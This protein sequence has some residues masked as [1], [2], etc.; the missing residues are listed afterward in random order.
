MPGLAF[1]QGLLE[2]IINAY[3]SLHPPTEHPHIIMGIEGDTLIGAVDAWTAVSRE[4]LTEFEDDAG[5][6]SNR[7]MTA[8]L[9]SVKYDTSVCDADVD[10]A[11]APPDAL[12]DM[13]SF[14]LEL[15][16][17]YAGQNV[18][19]TTA[20]SDTIDALEG[21]IVSTVAQSGA[22]Y[23]EEDNP[24][25]W[26]FL[27]GESGVSL[28]TPFQPTEIE[29]TPY[30]PWQTLWY[31]G[32]HSYFLE[33]NVEIRNPHPFRF[34]TPAAEVTWAAVL[35]RFWAEGEIRPGVDVDTFFCTAE[36]IPMRGE[37]A[38]LQ[39]ALRPSNSSITRGD[40]LTI[41]VTISNT[42][43]ASATDP[44]LLFQAHS[45]PLDW[46]QLQNT[47]PDRN[48]TTEAPVTRCQLPAMPP[49]TTQML[50]L[51]YQTTTDGATSSPQLAMQAKIFAATFEPNPVDNQETLRIDVLPAPGL[52]LYLPLVRWPD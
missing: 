4:L 7:L 27:G 33:E 38:D 19:L 51:V 5:L 29:G 34:I 14:A 52:A 35:A 44:V 47:V 37:T 25:Y 15:G 13:K 41:A 10:W 28:W 12:S 17:V 36:L 40:S 32:T 48:C 8:Y 31:T 9:N 16:A 18:T 49:N 42:R 21:T 24:D 3:H 22:P 50:R 23:F 11:L 39:V 1:E 43:I 26:S 20:L 30:L 45:D 46:L 2:D 6:T